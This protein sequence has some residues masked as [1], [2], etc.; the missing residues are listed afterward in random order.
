MYIIIPKKLHECPFLCPYPVVEEPPQDDGKA[1]EGQIVLQHQLRSQCPVEKPG[2]RGV[3]QI[4]S[5]SRS[6]R[7]TQQ[8]ER[9]YLYIPSVTKRCPGCFLNATGCEKLFPAWIIAVE[10]SICPTITIM[11]PV[12]SSDDAIS[13]IAVLTHPS[14]KHTALWA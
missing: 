3:S 4:P 10:R 6:E 11:I 2:I 5:S 14:E 12:P 8:R 1:Q 9:A 13:I 7:D